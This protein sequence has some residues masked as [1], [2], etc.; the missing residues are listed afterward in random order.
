LQPFSA[1][2]FASVFGA[3][4]G[5][6]MIH[7][8]EKKLSWAAGPIG[9]IGRAFSMLMMEKI[10]SRP[11]FTRRSQPLRISALTCRIIPDEV[12]VRTGQSA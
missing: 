12:V 6:S 3:I 9:K 4:V 10:P 5:I 2:G 8:V 11:S 1:T 7:A